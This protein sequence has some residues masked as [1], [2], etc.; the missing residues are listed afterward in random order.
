M[1]TRARKG[2]A[3]EQNNLEEYT[4]IVNLLKKLWADECGAVIATEYL[5]LG[6]I[7]AVGGATGLVSMR[8]AMTSEYQ[9]F[10][11]SV[12]EM[13]QH[14]TPAGLTGK[15]AKAPEYQFADG[16]YVPMNAM[17]GMAP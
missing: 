5:M 4:V 8:D 15:K 6:S 12:R 3:T 11:N 13:R 1:F 7:V 2:L 17:A 9:E 14:H 16:E 10:G